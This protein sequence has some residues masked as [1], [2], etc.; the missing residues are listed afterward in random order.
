MLRLQS[1][2]LITDKLFLKSFVFHKTSLTWPKILFMALASLNYDILKHMLDYV[3]RQDRLALA[4]T[5]RSFTSLAQENQTV[6]TVLLSLQNPRS[7]VVHS[8]FWLPLEMQG[9]F[10]IVRLTRLSCLN[11]LKF[12]NRFNSN[13]VFTDSALETN[14]NSSGHSRAPYSNITR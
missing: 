14:G 9:N 2:R 1:L 11:E 6:P 12:V 7:I 13:M 3:N 4:L 8:V 5:S 10:L